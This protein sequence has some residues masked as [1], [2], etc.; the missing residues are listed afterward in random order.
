VDACTFSSNAA[1][2]GTS[3]GIYNDAG[4]GG[5]AMLTVRNSTLDGN[6]AHSGPAGGGAGGAIYNNGPFSLL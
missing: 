6:S 4:N 1:T 3:G 5:K 2:N